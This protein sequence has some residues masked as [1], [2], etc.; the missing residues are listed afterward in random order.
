MTNNII[1][2]S[3]EWLEAKKSKIG[4]SEIFS[5]VHYYFPK[6]LEELGVNLSKEQPFKTA[7]ELFIKIKFGVEDNDISEVNS[8]FGKL[9]EG[10]IC[11]LLRKERELELCDFKRTQDFIIN[12]KLHTLAACSPDGYV[13]L[14]F[15]EVGEEIPFLPDFDKTCKIIAAWGMGILEFKTTDYGFNFEAEKGCKWSYI[16]QLQHNLL[17]CGAKWGILAALSPREKQFDT[18]FFKGRVLGIMQAG[19]NLPLNQYYNLNYYVYPA[20]PRIQDLILKALNTFQTDLDSDN[21]PRAST[22]PA[23]VQ[24]ERK[25]IA[26]AFPEHYGQLEADKELDD[27]INQRMIANIEAKKAE[28]EATELEIEIVKRAHSYLQVIGSNFKAAWDKRGGLRF[29]KL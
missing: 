12:D 10:P 29:Y 24:R 3:P 21:Y 13:E 25:V 27:L 28:S 23:K 2:H 11:D 14:P 4:G 22:H 5:L 7:L 6:E 15:A 1:Q 8:E 20:M 18:D 19:Q 17:V 16:M 9:M 26:M